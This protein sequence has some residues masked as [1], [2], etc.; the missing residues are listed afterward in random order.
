MSTILPRE[1]TGLPE[2]VPLNPLQ[3]EV[4]PYIDKEH[5]IMEAAP[6]A[7]GKSTVMY[8][9]GYKWL[10]RGKKIVYIGIMRALAQEKSDDLEEENHPWQDY[11]STVISGDYKMNADKERE[12]SEADI[13]CIT[14]ESL[15]SRLRHPH[16]E[17]NAWL[18]DVGMLVVDEIHLLSQEDRGTNLEAA[19]IEFTWE[20]PSVQIIGLSATVPNYAQIGRWLTHLNGKYTKVINSSYRPVP[21]QYHFVPYDTDGYRAH[22]EETR[23]ELI[24]QLIYDHPEDQFMVG[25]WHKGYGDKIATHVRERMGLRCD[26]HNANRDRETKRAIV[27]QF[28]GGNLRVLVATSTLFTGVN[29]PARRIIITA[30]EAAKDDIPVYEL[31]QAAGR[32]GRPRFDPAGDAYFLIPRNRFDHHVQ[33]IKAG[34]EVMSHMHVQ[35]WLAM[36]LLGAI[37][38]NRVAD[39]EDFREWFSR[40]LAQHQQRYSEEALELMLRGVLDDLSVRGMIKFDHISMDFELLHRGKI[41]AQMYLDPYHFYDMLSNI[42]TYVA[43]SRPDDY[44]LASA[45]GR[46]AGFSSLSVTKAEKAGIPEEL[47]DYEIPTRYLKAV[48]VVY[49]RIKGYQIAPSLSNTAYSVLEDMPRM[50]AAVSRAY[51][52]CE[53]WAV[54]SDRLDAI[55]VRVMKRCSEQEAMLAIKQFTKGERKKL[56]AM[57]LYSLRDVQDNLQTAKQ[58]LTPSRMVELNLMTA[59]GVLRERKVPFGGRATRTG[60]GK[61]DY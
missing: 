60:Y 23:L 15:A 30:V 2:G 45:I 58:A 5:N 10:K 37:Y 59:D 47:D 33:R 51:E 43:L 54:T 12:I 49:M 38:L 53:R 46:C 36:H 6:T 50:H 1:Y 8:M 24:E 56:A 35:K 31:L 11:K 55:F 26:F 13:I 22:S 18:E 20:F 4:L 9:C 17:R 21:L 61:R 16:A 25:V 29:M 39:L 52:E 48:A 28:K 42:S 7:S 57:G 19:L 41:A 44:D 14:P 32:A 34:E 27:K 40:T 3:E